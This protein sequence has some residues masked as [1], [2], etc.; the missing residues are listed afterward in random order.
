MPVATMLAR[1]ESICGPLP[2]AMRLE[3]HS[4]YRYYTGG[5]LLYHVGEDGSV[6]RL[7]PE[8]TALTTVIPHGDPLFL[9]LLSRLLEP[10]PSRRASATTA[11]QHP[12]LRRRCATRGCWPAC[13]V[14]CIAAVAR[15]S[16]NN[17]VV[18]WCFKCPDTAT[19]S[20]NSS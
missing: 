5:G 9:D 3:G 20:G 1:V 4:T 11:L 18:T 10:D 2:H 13:R 7:R 8:P 19:P 12:W 15:V 6:E 14:C 16:K 17:R